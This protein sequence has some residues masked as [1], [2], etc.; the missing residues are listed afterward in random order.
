[1][2][3]ALQNSLRN[4]TGGMGQVFKAEDVKLARTVAIKVL[5]LSSMHHAGARRRL[6]REARAASALNHPSIVTIHAIEQLHP[7][8]FIVMEYIEGESLRDV[9]QNGPLDLQRLLDLG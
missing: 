8:S 1:M 6:L 5:P 7:Y 2:R 3:F 4:W 9:L